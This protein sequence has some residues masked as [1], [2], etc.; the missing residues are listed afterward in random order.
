LLQSVYAQVNL[1]QRYR[2][3]FAY[4][5]GASHSALSGQGSFAISR[6]LGMKAHLTT[7][8]A[9]YGVAVGTPDYHFDLGWMSILTGDG[10]INE[11]RITAGDQLWQP[12]LFAEAVTFGY[13]LNPGVVATFTEL[14]A[15]P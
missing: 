13:S 10:F 9:S 11:Q 2:L 15:E 7:I 8:P 1:L 6:L 14:E 12:E 3:P 4:I 5:A